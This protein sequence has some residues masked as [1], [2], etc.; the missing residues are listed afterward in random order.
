MS[1]TSRSDWSALEERLSL[2]LEAWSAARMTA[3]FWW[4]DDDAISDTPQLRRLLDV[5]RDVGIAPALA[6]IPERVDQTLARALAAADCAVWQHGWGHHFHEAG[7]FGDGRP[8]HE[9]MV[10]AL[11]GR[12]ALDGLFGASRWQRVFVPPNH[13]LS[14]L[15]KAV[16]P[17]LEYLGVSAGDPL[18]LGIEH[19]AE[20]NAEVDVMDWPRGT[21]LSGEAVSAMLV[22]QLEAR[23][24][25]AVPA[26]RPIGVLTHHLAFDDRA[27]D[28]VAALFRLIRS[29]RAVEV[30]RD[31]KSTRLNSSHL[32]IS[33]AVFCLKKKKTRKT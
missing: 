1:S 3:K 21:L 4:R 15:F 28:L 26:K 14:M 19:V 31:R 10:D 29:H 2:E 6:V 9:M 32:V 27:W 17:G 11:K 5:A 22:R 16:M 24:R 18:T 8:L 33:Y 12:R 25:G 30:L 13:M 20:V 7:E 23:R